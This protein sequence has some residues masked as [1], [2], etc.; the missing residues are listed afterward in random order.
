MDKKNQ[1]QYCISDADGTNPIPYRLEPHDDYYDESLR[2]SL[3]PV[4]YN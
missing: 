1:I 3:W 4:V 2:K